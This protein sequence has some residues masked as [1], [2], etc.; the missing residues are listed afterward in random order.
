MALCGAH[1]PDWAPALATAQPPQSPDVLAW[2]E[3]QAGSSDGGQRLRLAALAVT[4]LGLAL[5]FWGLGTESIWLD[6]VTSIIIARMDLPSVIAWAAGDIHPPLYYVALHFWRAL[7]ESEFA[8]RSLSAALG[9]VSILVLYGLAAELFGRRVGLVAALFLALSPLHIWYSQEARMYVMLTL[10]VL[11]S[12]YLMVLAL[13]RQ[14]RRYWLGY[15]VISALALYTH[16]FALFGLLFQNVLAAYWFWRKKGRPWQRWL[17]AQL[18]IALLFSPW[19]PTLYHQVTTGGGGWVERSIGQPTLY[20][21]FDTWLYFSIGLDNQLYP[22]L[23]R[24]VSYVMFALAVASAVAHVV[25]PD[26]DG[27]AISDREGLWFC[28]LYLCLPVGTVWLVSQLKPMYSVRYLLAFMPPY[29]I[30]LAKGLVSLRWKTAAAVLTLFLA[31]TLLIGDW[32]A[33]R[34]DQNPDWR[35][36]TSYVLEQ[37]QTG[38]VVLFSPRWNAKPFEYY[39]Q[40]RIDINMDLPIP[41]TAAT[42]AAVIEDISGRYQRVWLVWTRGHYSDPDGLV[43]QRLDQRYD[44]LTDQ[45]FRGVDR[46]IL[47]DLKAKDSP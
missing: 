23:W 25:R 5:R 34:S 19:L 9:A 2:S 26:R 27:Q 42:S 37:A 1:A 41:V 43:K 35:G 8:I 40:G 18:A 7:G 11:M 12:S 3:R 29:C 16:Y 45:A 47:Y 24:R 46:L 15:V 33:W 13:R 10:W 32:N 21:L 30:L 14:D 44:V 6:E 20:A 36:L 22:V 17:W 4:L 38:D 39:S 28:L 31:A